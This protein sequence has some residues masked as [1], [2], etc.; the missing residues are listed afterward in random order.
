M[1]LY[2]IWNTKFIGRYVELSKKKSLDVIIHDGVFHSDDVFSVALLDLAFDLAMDKLPSF[3]PGV[4]ME[5]SNFITWRSRQKAMIENAH[6]AIDVGKQYDGVKYFDHHQDDVPDNVI[7]SIPHSA[8]GLLAETLITEK[9]VLDELRKAVIFGIEA[10]D[11]GLKVPDN[12][13]TAGEWVAAM[14]PNWDETGDTHMQFINAAFM[15]KRMLYSSIKKIIAVIKAE[16][17]ID[18]LIPERKYEK[19]LVLDK[20]MPWE[21]H[22]FRNYPKIIAAVYLR[23]GGWRVKGALAESENDLT[24]KMYFPEGFTSEGMT[25]LHKHRFMAA[26]DTKEHAIEAALKSIEMQNL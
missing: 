21:T 22:V 3:T 17:Y 23:D 12:Y 25:F 20:N 18:K 1:K 7:D 24:Q 26:F 6:I 19:L 2:S 9:R 16:E 15:A 5:M 11:N 4:N 10:R 8:L 13:N 14:N